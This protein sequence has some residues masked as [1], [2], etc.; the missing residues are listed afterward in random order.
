M[1]YLAGPRDAMAFLLD[2]IEHEPSWLRYNNQDAWSQYS[3][4]LGGWRT[5]VRSARL[6]SVFLRQCPSKKYGI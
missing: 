1:R 4:L 5:E 3:H 2:R 6:L